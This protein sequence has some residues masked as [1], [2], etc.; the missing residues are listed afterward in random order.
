MFTKTKIKLKIIKIIIPHYKVLSEL[1]C[2]E[3]L[4]TND[5]NLPK[6]N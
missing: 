6:I 4:K 5:G 3:N 2:Y 1:I